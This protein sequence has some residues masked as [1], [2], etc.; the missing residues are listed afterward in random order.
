[1]SGS[2]F[3]FHKSLTTIFTRK[4]HFSWFFVPMFLIVVG[5]HCFFTFKNFVTYR[6]ILLIFIHDFSQ[7]SHLWYFLFSWTIFTWVVN[8]FWYFGKCYMAV[9][10][11]NY[12]HIWNDPLSL[13]C[14]W[15]L[16]QKFH[17]YIVLMLQY[18]PYSQN[19]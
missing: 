5:H 1:M 13:Y 8:C 17:T 19:K 18:F 3:T 6:A 7:E 2:I 16:F 10:T 9:L 12:E 4:S 15:T 14:S 11:Q